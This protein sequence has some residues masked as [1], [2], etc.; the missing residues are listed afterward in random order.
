[1][2]FKRWMAMA[3]AAVL[4]FGTLAGCGQS[5]KKT[6]STAASAE[7]SAEAS[8]KKLKIVATI[9]PEYDWVR[10]ILGDEAK[11]ADITLLLDKG[12]D[13]HSY[14]PNAEDIAKISECDLFL[15]VGGESD[16]WVKDALKEGKNP[17]R[18]VI[19]LLEALG[20][21]TKEEEVV[22]GMQAEEEEGSKDSESTAASQAAESQ[23]AGESTAASAE[24]EEEE[25]PEYDEHVWLSLRNAE[26]IC[27]VITEDLK[28]LDSAHAAVYEAN[29]KKYTEQL[30]S[31]D[32]Q[33]TDTVKAAANKT[34]LFGDRFPFRYLVDDYGIKYY[35]AFVGCSA[36]TEASFETVSFLAKKMD[37][38]GL[39]HVMTI[40]GPNKK[41]A[42][43]IIQNTKDKNQDI[44]T[45]NSMQ[46]TTEQD[47][48]SGETYL[49]I[50]QQN[51]E[52][53]KK[54]LQ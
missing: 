4:A 53:L 7:S 48:E 15:Y 33:Y 10:Q 2:K 20:N 32:Q 6:E 1:M 17:D 45:L 3:T 42:E 12:V 18:K 39:K 54:A 47:I 40:E 52:V 28:S 41:I 24:S 49:G 31:L 35:A 51:L 36:E 19:N 50:M 27:E 29:L 14:Q 13:L 5:G 43:T 16:G 22:E 25:G 26:S 37:E 21:N 8:G 9:F 11:N 38:L 46:S 23:A 34:L 44:L 30:D